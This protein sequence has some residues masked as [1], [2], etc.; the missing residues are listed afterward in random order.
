MKPPR[1]RGLARRGASVFRNNCSQW[2]GAGAAGVQASGYPNLLD[3]DWLW[4]GQIEDIA[5]T[6]R[7]GIRN[8]EDIDV[9]W[10]KYLPSRIFCEAAEVTAIAAF[11][12]S[13][14][15]LDHD[16][17]LA[18]QG[19]ALFAERAAP[20]VMA[21]TALETAMS[22]LRTCRTR[23]GCVAVRRTPSSIRSLPPSGCHAALKRPS[24]RGGGVCCRG[25][26]S[27]PAG[28]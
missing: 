27:W 2:Y 19:A 23:S 26:C 14:S 13:L 22:G 20:P 11:L 10:S 17:A 15:G 28:R 9:R 12:R 6:I 4:G 8:E 25:L 18:I 3:D 7:H 21:R 16:A 5:Y 1:F 24:E